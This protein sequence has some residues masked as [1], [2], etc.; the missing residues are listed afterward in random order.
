MMAFGIFDFS[1]WVFSESNG[2]GDLNVWFYKQVHWRIQEQVWMVERPSVVIS[3]NEG[4]RISRNAFQTDF[5]PSKHK[6]NKDTS[7]WSKRHLWGT[8]VSHHQVMIAMKERS[9]WKWWR[10][11]FCR[12]LSCKQSK[13]RCSKPKKYQTISDFVETFVIICPHKIGLK[14]WGEQRLQ[15]GVRWL[16]I[17]HESRSGFHEKFSVLGELL[18]ALVSPWR[19]WLRNFLLFVHFWM[20]RTLWIFLRCWSKA[21]NTLNSA[22]VK[23]NTTQ[24]TLGAM[25]RSILVSSER[26]KTTTVFRL[27]G[28]DCWPWASSHFCSGCKKG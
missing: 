18:V 7:K 23:T 2:V 21:Q 12:E 27:L 6:K 15:A 24:N 28:W 14:S 3:W 25:L 16:C 1:L 9:L 17:L 19:T 22:F 4:F 11:T 5:L 13:T 20:S 8:E 10:I 26:N